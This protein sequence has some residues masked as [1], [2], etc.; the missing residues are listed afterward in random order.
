MYIN[1][2]KEGKKTLLGLLEKMVSDDM[3]I[4]LEN[5]ELMNY[6]LEEFILRNR[7]NENDLRKN[8]QIF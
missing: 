2:N 7:E 6:K 1:N 8:M 4:Y 5:Q 3:E